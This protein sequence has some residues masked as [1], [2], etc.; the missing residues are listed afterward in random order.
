VIATGAIANFRKAPKEGQAVA[1]RK[2]MLQSL[3][4]RS[5]PLKAHPAT[6]AAF[7]LI[8]ESAPQPVP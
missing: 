5:H 2:A 4:D 3:A 1:L 7:S 6:W 8:G